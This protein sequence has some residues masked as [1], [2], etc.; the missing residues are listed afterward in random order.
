MEKNDGGP[1][2]EPG[3]RW[4]YFKDVQIAVFNCRESHVNAARKAVI[5]KY[6][7]GGWKTVLQCKRSGIMEIFQHHASPELLLFAET[8]ADGAERYHSRRNKDIIEAK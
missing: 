1:A 6:G 5:K 3:E 7:E 8:V 2:V 4:P